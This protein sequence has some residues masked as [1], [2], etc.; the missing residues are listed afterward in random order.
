MSEFESK[1]SYGH[2]ST[3]WGRA[4]SHPKF[5]DVGGGRIE[6]VE[7]HQQL[8]QGPYGKWV[9]VSRKDLAKDKAA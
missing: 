4:Q 8:T 7:T 5:I 6:H 3:R 1:P 9:P 2:S